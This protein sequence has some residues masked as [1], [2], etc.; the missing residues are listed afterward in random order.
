MKS[1]LD[2]FDFNEETDLPAA[3][4]S[5]KFDPSNPVDKFLVLQKV[6]QGEIKMKEINNLKL[7]VDTMNNSNNND[8]YAASTAFLDEGKDC[9]VKRTFVLDAVLE[10]GSNLI[11]KLPQFG[12]NKLEP[13]SSCS[14][15]EGR[16]STE[17]ASPANSKFKCPRLESS[18]SDESIDADESL[19]EI[20]QSTFSDIVEND[21]PLDGRSSDHCFGNW[22]MVDGDSVVECFPDYIVYRDKYSTDSVITFSSSCIKIKGSTANGENGTFV[23]QWEVDDII[24]IESHW[25][26][27]FELAMVKIRVISKG[28]VPIEDVHGSSGI[29]ELKFA[30]VE[31]WYEK[32]DAITSFDVY[33]PLW[34]IV[35][36]SHMERDAKALLGRDGVFSKCYF[37]IFDE[38]FEDVIYP[39]GDPD[40]VSIS[41]R[42]V[43]LLQPDTFVNDTII[44]FYI[45][46]LKNKIE[47][48]ERH[49]F[50]FFNC[51]FFRKLADLDKNPSSA[52]EGRAAFQRVRKWTRKINLFEKDYVFIPVNFN[53]HWSLIVICHPGEVA[54]FQGADPVKSPKVPCILHMDSIRGSHSGLKGL[55]QSYLLEEWKE[56]QKDT[57]EDISSR[58]L[59]LRFLSL[60]LPQQQNSYDCG[61]FLLHYVELFLKKIPVDFNP[62]KITKFS[63]F[64][65]AD[66][67]QPLE[68]SLKRACIERLIYELLD[69]GSHENAPDAGSDK[70]K[71][72]TSSCPKSFDENGTTVEFLSE[73]CSPTKTFYG[74]VPSSQA[75][76]GIEL[77]L[78]PTSSLKSSQCASD[79][80]LVL[81]ELFDPRASVYQTFE[82]S[83]PF[84][85]YENAMPRTEGE[86]ETGMHFGYSPSAQTGF[87]RLT[88]I[89]PEGSGPYLST[90]FG[91]EPSWNP[92]STVQQTAHDD[93][94]SL[95]VT[96]ICDDSLEAEETND[97]RVGI[98]LS[99][100]VKI[101]QPGYPLTDNIECLP[102]CLAPTTNE[103]LDPDSQNNPGHMLNGNDN[104]DPVTPCP[105]DLLGLTPQQCDTQENGIET[106]EGEQSFSDDSVSEPN[107]QHATKKR[108]LT[109]LEEEEVLPRSLA[110]DL[111]L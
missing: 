2:V 29:E 71:N 104:A 16:T 36:D 111:H 93:I 42:D 45:K 51:F 12:P 25:C 21:V 49:R 40:A 6:A 101:D 62:F 60:E 84:D 14:Q 1:G 15:M 24:N 83:A 89:T 3:K 76:K 28:E 100:E 9:A 30:I 22:Q 102:D 38:H 33:K 13:R 57:P 80:G 69:E 75:G 85:A 107:V 11:E 106:C 87:E 50:H 70:I 43:D 10:N 17:V 54:E 79:S 44:D 46:Y 41:K 96:S 52:L 86:E 103:L 31:D 55:L 20:S 73:R 58:F 105:K 32:Q 77:T 72:C 66:W 109:P 91:G 5:R 67:F 8:D 78:L 82:Q 4:Y 88:A 65:T 110:G 97:S 56:R 95:P 48:G 34:N 61:L 90:G 26:E 63:N 39:K 64:L 37:P 68:A 81:R 35:L 23:F 98:N 19:S 27:R 18:S 94:D 47:P 99:L 92:E 74:N 59:N 7:N 53:Y 108:R